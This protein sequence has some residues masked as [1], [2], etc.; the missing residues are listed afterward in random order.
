LKPLLKIL[1]YLVATVVLGTL[2]APPLYWG[3][4][5]LASQDILKWLADTPFRKFF[6]RGLLIA[7]LVLL[8][9][10]AK[11][12]KI[13]G[14]QALGL[15]HNPRW[16]R[17]AAT[18]L[19]VSFLMMTLLAVVLISIHFV[20]LKTGL[21]LRPFLKIAGSA[22]TVAFLEEW[23]F[24]GAILGLLARTLREGWALFAT[25]ALFSV[26]HFL[27]PETGHFPGPVGW[28]SGF[29]LIPG[30]FAQFSDPW[31]VAGGFTTLFCLGWLLGWARLKTRSLA[32][33]IGLHAG[34]VIGFMSFSKATKRMMR[35]QD[36][37]PWFGGDLKVGLGSVIVVLLTGAVVW[38]IL[39]RRSRQQA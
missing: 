19:L 28:F 20:K 2:L 39:R 1:L 25:S 3:G 15:N 4:Q 35:V 17:D 11:W 5:W 33:S 26:L 30:S 31:M 23:L 29:K 10:T 34:I 38:I 22:I 13:H 12:L 14:T 32:M 36:T 7:A 24:R 6:H 21:H 27:K 16:W 18:G 37:L 8:W 9:P